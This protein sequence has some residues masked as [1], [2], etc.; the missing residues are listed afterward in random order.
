MRSTLTSV[1]LTLLIFIA[2][3]TFAQNPEAADI[4]KSQNKKLTRYEE[5]DLQQQAEFLIA[6]Q[7]GNLEA[8]K[9]KF[10]PH[11]FYAFDDGGENALTRAIKNNDEEMVQFLEEKA[12][13]NL[14]NAEGELPYGR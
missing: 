5:T 10:K 13:I 3:S 12:V 7:S 11:Y 2:T 9:D 1:L 4:T 8:A 6:V 14:A